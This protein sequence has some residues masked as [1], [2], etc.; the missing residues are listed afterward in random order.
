MI[1]VRCASCGWSNVNEPVSTEP[2]A[3]GVRLK[4]HVECGIEHLKACTAYDPRIHYPH[5]RF[6][7]E[8]FEVAW[9]PADGKW[10]ARFTPLLEETIFLE[11]TTI[12]AFLSRER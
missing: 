11:G 8:K 1:G 10:G 4:D 5:F 9:T 7:R 6:G 12:A 2:V 3:G